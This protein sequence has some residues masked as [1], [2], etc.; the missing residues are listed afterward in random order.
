[1][2]TVLT[3]IGAVFNSRSLMPISEDLNELEA[4]TSIGEPL[5]TVPQETPNKKVKLLE[6]WKLTQQ[7]VQHFWDRW[8]NE[9]ISRLQQRPK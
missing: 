4:P 8:S 6:A 2:Y 7:I 5:V 1:M 9:Y 3:Q